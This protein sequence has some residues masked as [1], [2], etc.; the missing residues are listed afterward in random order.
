MTG[1]IA[2]KMGPEKGAPQGGGN[3]IT[4]QSVQQQ[5]HL[6]PTQAEQMQR[7][8][9]AGMKVMFDQKTHQLMQQQ[10]QGPG[11]LPD[12]MGKGVAALV[13][14]LQKEANGSL[15]AKLLIPAGMVLVAQA[16]AF[17]QETGEKVTDKDIAAA[18]AVMIGTLLRSAGV[19]PDKLPGGQTPEQEAA[20]DPAEEATETP[21]EE[22][23]EGGEP[24]AEEGA[25]PAP[26]SQ[27]K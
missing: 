21:A 2:S 23:A 8:V 5:M 22:E 24:P 13:V 17:L 3:T 20:E 9:A 7:I 10:L 15:P 25:E 27:E 1:L 14:L 6:D 11:P 16:A 26:E 18:T 19:N 12:K 4:P